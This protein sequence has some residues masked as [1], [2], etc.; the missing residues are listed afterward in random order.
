MRNLALTLALTTLACP[1]VADVPRVV[2]DIPAVQS[3]TA[4]VMG[5]LG[6][7]A[8]LLEQGGNAHSYQLRPSQAKTL[9][10]ADLVIWVGPEMTPWLDRAVAGVGGTAKPLGLLAAEPTHRRPFTAAEVDEHGH[11]AD[12]D[13][14]DTDPHA[15][16]DPENAKVWVGLIAADL[17]AA[18]PEHAATYHQNA[19]AA[20]ARIDAA[21]AEAA[22]LLAPVANRPFVVFHDAYGYFADRFGLHIA[23]A[24]NL[25][26]A[27][28]PG[29]AH[30]TALRDAM[31]QNGVVCAF[32]EAGHDPRPVTVLVEGTGVHVGGALDPSGSGLPYGPALYEG[33]LGQMAATLAECLSRGDG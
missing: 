18:D 24:I 11:N 31:A 27:T 14:G 15:W 17:A 20:R 7:P 32:P 28:T 9:Q 10:G 13:H 19:D 4:Q 3:L 6:M 26:D 23:G 21:Q 25:G 22:T 8:V 2:T 16:L 1:S 33:L 12:H 29:A 30:L 5:D